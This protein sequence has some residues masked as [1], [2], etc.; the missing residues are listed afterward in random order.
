MSQWEHEIIEVDDDDLPI[1]KH[2]IFD[3]DGKVQKGYEQFLYPDG[4]CFFGSLFDVPSEV[5]DSDLPIKEGRAVSE[6]E[7]DA[8][9][10]SEVKLSAAATPGR[11]S[12]TVSATPARQNNAAE[13]P[14]PRQPSASKSSSVKNGASRSRSVTASQR[15]ASSKPAAAGSRSQSAASS[16]ARQPSRS[17]SKAKSASKQQPAKRSRSA[18]K[19]TAKVDATWTVEALRAFAKENDINL[20]G[21]TTKQEILKIISKA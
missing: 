11:K 14:A 19:E 1:L 2:R 9:L 7:V 6:K 15:S 3:N 5:P 18:T 10:A 4:C 12:R 8:F 21:V 17:L 13:T 16:K 20:R